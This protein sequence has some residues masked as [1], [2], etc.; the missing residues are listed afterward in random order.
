MYIQ[1]TKL[2]KKDECAAKNKI[3]IQHKWNYR[4]NTWLC[5][6]CCL[7]KVLNMQ[8]EEF[9]K[10]ECVYRNEESGSENW[11]KMSQKKWQWQNFTLKEQLE[12]FHNIWSPKD[13][14][15][16]TNPNLES[17]K[18]NC[19]SIG[20]MLTLIVNYTFTVLLLHFYKQNTSI[21]KIHN[22]LNYGLL[23]NY[24]FCFFYYQ[25]LIIHSKRDSNV[26]TKKNINIME[27]L[28]IFLLVIKI[29][30]NSL[31]L[32]GLFY[33]PAIPGKERTTCIREKGKS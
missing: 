12:I 19:Q 20:K 1:K 32:Y 7:S 18:T 2:A 33:S 10:G 8:P 3:W 5:W 26:F 29:T 15:L 21:L 24:Y 22:I 28:K 25:P 23:S 13:K 16:D 31:T 27:K 11:I 17:S 6:Q 14:L 4:R 9:N 30:L